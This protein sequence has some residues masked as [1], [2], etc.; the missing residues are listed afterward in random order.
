MKK[1]LITLG[2]AFVLLLCVKTAEADS[3]EDLLS[4]ADSLYD[5][6]NLDS[7]LILG[8]LALAKA[9]DEFGPEDTIVARVMNRL[10]AYDL[11]TF[12][13]PESHKVVEAR[14]KRA[15][16]I[17]EKA[18]GEEHLEVA[19]ASFYLGVY[20]ANRRR[21][22]EAEPLLTRTL[23]IRE[24]I[25]GSDHL[26]TIKSL[27]DLGIIY[28]RQNKFCETLSYLERALAAR[29][30]IL[31][32]NH[33]DVA[34]ILYLLGLSY[35]IQ[36]KYA[37]AEAFY[38][39]ALAV[40][41]KVLGSD[42]P[43]VAVCLNAMGTLYLDQ[44]NYVQA[45]SLYARSFAIKKETL[46]PD[47]PDLAPELV[48]MAN[49]Y[50]FRGNI[51]LAESL[52]RRA[53]ETSETTLGPHHPDVATSLNNLV[54]IYTSQGR[55]REAE[56]FAKQS[57][58]IMEDMFGLDHLEITPSLDNLA[59]AC[60]NQDKFAEAESLCERSL[61]IKQETVG[62]D[63]PSVAA[64][65]GNLG[66][67][68]T[69]KG[70]YT[71]AASF[72]TRSLDIR[73]KAL[74]SNHPDVAS[75]LGY[76]SELRRI[77]GDQ[78]RALS[79]AERACRIRRENFKENGV[80]LSERDALAY[81]QYF[82]KSIDKYLTCY[83]ELEDVNKAV[84]EDA[85][86]I[87]IS[88]KGQVSDVMF[89][90]QKALVEETDSATVALAESLRLAKYNLSRLFVQGPD[91][92]LGEYKGAVDSLSRLA[93]ELEADLSRNSAS[94]R[95]RRE[96]GDVTAARVASLLPKKAVLVEYLKYN[97]HQRE[98]D[99][100]IPRYFAVVVAEGEEP[101][102]IDLGSASELD[103]LVDSYRKHM[104]RVSSLGK[105]L[106]EDQRAYLDISLELYRRIWLPVAH[107]VA[108]KDLV[109][110]APDGALNMISFAGLMDVDGRYLVENSKI[111]YL[112]CGRDLVRLNDEAGRS[113]GLFAVGDPDY[114]AA[115]SA[116][117][118][119]PMRS[120]DTEAEAM[121]YATRNVRS[122][123]LKLKET[124]LSPLPATRSEVERV[125]ANWRESTDE[126]ANFYLGPDASEDRFKAEAP[127]S[128]V[129]HL[130]THG[131][132]LGN[133]CKPDITASELSSDIGYVGEN[134]LML[135]GLFFAGANLHG[136]GA[137]SA[138][139]EDGILT[140][141][142]VSAMDLE[143]T[144]LVVLSACET[145][146][147]KVQEGEGVYGLR[148]AFQMAGAMTVVS[149]LW[150][151]SDQ[152]TAEMMTELY[153]SSDRPL[154]ER[155]R[156]SQLAQIEK[157]RSQKLVDHA[158]NWAAFIAVGDWR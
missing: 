80:L 146:L 108:G 27:R 20:C 45:E 59:I 129:I 96:R 42:H 102:T 95:K 119:E 5:A 36:G 134:P 66:I 101:A 43:D 131:Y 132:F 140:A 47:H 6:D 153:T 72:H 11:S 34:E 133:E 12:F 128:R 24:K 109:L 137:D 126:S 9:E 93:N 76:I 87:V 77:L 83:S 105:P 139:A 68:H 136:Q 4:T 86:D 110:I 35:G 138:G 149:A 56:F 75:S 69:Y 142:E 118:L 114:D 32:R 70:E 50:R 148:R 113:R 97:H 115:A 107:R 145:A 98:S 111:H 31:G 33:P 100:I 38:R 121:Q 21:Y 67:I 78:A 29:E 3:W 116:R 51:E 57:L 135:S 127:G 157:L 122:S 7:A 103:S 49:L 91:G 89:E 81:S 1:M 37:Q 48:S 52:Y 124:L 120:E 84:C 22:A 154:C 92:D 94:F 117:L 158:Y 53:L 150:P 62:P 152:M 8:K 74:G 144:D 41:E 104:L 156:D 26:K 151:V 54:E 63:H 82:R 14:M 147:G 141:Y 10:S 79:L 61:G 30:R 39:Q 143:G 64:T 65:L 90:R 88:G 123:C 58:S 55:L 46:G 44:G 40:R 16:A 73:E 106:D 155:I 15:L 19:E 85:A 25:L 13:L 125:V 17:C 60:A 71:Q 28:L 18:Y 112:T 99:A 23:T 2:A 130:A